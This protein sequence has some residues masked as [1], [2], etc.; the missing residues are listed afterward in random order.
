MHGDA[1]PPLLDRRDAQM[2][3]SASADRHLT[4]VDL[5]WRS[6]SY[7]FDWLPGES[8]LDN[9]KLKNTSDAKYGVGAIC[10]VTGKLC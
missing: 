5:T 7:A 2:V 4:H 6:R 3:A 10:E 8:D 1:E 9:M